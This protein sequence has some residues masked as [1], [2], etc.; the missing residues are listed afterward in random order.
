MNDNRRWLRLGLATLLALVIGVGG[1]LFIRSRL[2]GADKIVQRGERAYGRGMDALEAG[3]AA[4]AAQQ[5]D[6][7]VLLASKSL[8][9]LEK[10]RQSAHAADVASIAPLEAQAY[11]LKFRA[12]RDR[13]YAQAAA[14]GKP[15]QAAFDTSTGKHFRTVLVVPDD[16]AR[17]EGIGCLRQAALRTPGNAEIQEEAL[18]VEVV[19]VPLQWGL[20]EK[21]ARNAIAANPQDARAQYL[22]AR[23]EFEQPATEGKAGN[24][25]PDKRKHDRVVKAL[26]HLNKL[27]EVDGYPR[28]RTLYLEAQVRTWL[29]DQA[30][31]KGKP[32]ERD[33]QDE[34]LRGVL[35]RAEAEARKLPENKEEL[36]RISSWDLDGMFALQL[37]LVDAAA[38]EVS[39]PDAD[40]TPIV[41][42]LSNLLAL[43]QKTTGKDASPAWLEKSAVT[44]LA[45]VAR[46]ETL[47][48]TNPP[49]QWSAHLSAVQA[50]AKKARDARVAT[51]ALYTEVATLLAREGYLE[52]RRNNKARQEEL[53]KQAVGWIEDGLKAGADGKA[54]ASELLGLHALAAEMKL[55][56]GDK[57]EAIA[58]H[59]AALKAS[60]SAEVK[61][62]A[63][64]LEGALAEREGRLEAARRLLEEA[65]AAAPALAL[66]AHLVLANVYLALDQPDRA[67]ASLAIVEKAYQRFEEMPT[68]DR[69]W[70][71]AFT[72]T[73]EDVTV[74]LIRA[75]LQTA[76]N[77]ATRMIAQQ[78]RPTEVAEALRLHEEPVDRLLS[79]L[80]EKTP[81]QRVVRQLLALHHAVTG[82]A[83]RAKEELAELR[84]DFPDSLEVL[85]TEA[86]VLLLPPPGKKEAANAPP[87]PEVV[88]DGD[89]LIQEFIDKHPKDSDAR[90]FK[91]EWLLRTQRTTEAVAYLQNAANFPDGQDERHKRLLGVALLV[92]GERVAG[93]EVLRHL[94]RDASIDALLI[95]AGSA[96]PAAMACSAAGRRPAP[97]PRAS[98][99]RRPRATCRRWS[100]PGSSRW[101]G[102]G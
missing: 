5:F 98:T 17:Q 47:V 14:E 62:T 102:K 75:H 34:A 90:L 29:R 12:I 81:Q 36:A 74:L 15:L 101:R 13:A 97:W 76:R 55:V 28:W 86:Q 77:R 49:P 70:A 93:V 7:A 39:K 84:K 61:A 89:K 54:P 4:N 82:R 9:E 95:Q 69:D 68:R 73:P 63:A 91:G 6:E 27:K 56:R 30:A 40:P 100:S 31:S 65:V 46:T 37:L 21:F 58:P 92:K 83:D 78:A 94:P 52:G 3:D 23:F 20:I 72:R 50:L 60:Q 1:F 2:T 59:L 18:K 32:E 43:C 45:A 57:R 38:A 53:T 67:L 71:L 22:L 48:G 85:R 96:P 64:L 80:K 25:P 16:K 66:R 79:R 42:A 99:P 51:P 33:R 26:E 11:W 41:D 24:T 19:L 35:K 88:K 87:A 10:K 8:D 44:A